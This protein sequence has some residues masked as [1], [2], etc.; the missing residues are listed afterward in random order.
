MKVK[1]LMY[2]KTIDNGGVE[3]MLLEWIQNIQG[4]DV[5][6]DVLTEEI[7]YPKMSDKYKKLGSKV[8][9]LPKSKVGSPK[10]RR[11]LH[12]ILQKEK[13]DIVHLHLCVSYQ[14][15][16]NQVAK[17]EGI[18]IRVTHSH[19]VITRDITFLSY[20]GHHIYKSLLRQYTTDCFAC[21]QEAGKSL[22]GNHKSFRVIHNGIDLESFVFDE[23]K[24]NK[25]RHKIGVKEDEILIGSVGRLNLQKNYS[26]LL[27]VFQSVRKKKRN[28]K[29][30]LVGTGVEEDVLKRTASELHIETNV[31]FFGGTD[32]VPGVMSAMD[33]FVLPS[34]F[35]G[36]GVVLVEAQAIGLPCIA[37][38]N[39]PCEVN[40][41]NTVKFLSL[42]ESIE[43]W[44]YEI[45]KKGI[46]KV[47]YDNRLKIKDTGY[48]IKD[49][50]LELKKWYVE[51]VEIQ[52]EKI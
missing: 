26:F 25:I 37:S 52:N 51:K 13:Y 39:V 33:V 50:A 19:N 30:V 45:I 11:K 46:Q 10:A 2:S 44:A 24:R 35:E 29:L 6:F 22:F 21:G 9:I 4:K 40:I 12:E 7:L 17:K 34:L 20:F 49:T 38:E 48:D 41:T 3:K 14:S 5:R 28:A 32:D 18:R 16:V 36:L 27:N 47:R 31:V 42:Q 43:V 1:V 8:Y 15:W 23:E